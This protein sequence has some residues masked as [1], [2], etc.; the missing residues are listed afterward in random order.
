MYTGLYFGHWLKS[1]IAA[2]AVMIPFVL[3][4]TPFIRR[5]V[6]A[7]TGESGTSNSTV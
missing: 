2:W 7:L 5:T 1:W 4:I 6:N 3:V